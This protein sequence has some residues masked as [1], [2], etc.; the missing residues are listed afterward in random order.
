MINNMIL[1][2]KNTSNNLILTL[3]EKT[4]LVNP[5]YLFNFKSQQSKN[6]FNFICSD[7]STATTRYNKFIL[8]ETGST[9]QN[10]TAGVVSLTDSGWYDYKVYE[11]ASS[12]NLE[13]SLAGKI[14]EE[15]LALV[16]ASTQVN[17]VSDA[18]GITFRT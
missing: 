6:E 18:G 5:F 14:V 15:G 4:T 8:V 2:N 1:I 11:Q 17:L 13:L 10:L 16:S 7:I 12:T 9:S 3:T